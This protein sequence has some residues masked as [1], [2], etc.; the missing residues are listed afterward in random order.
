M[1]TTPAATGATAP[2]TPARLRRLRTG[3]SRVLLWAT[4]AL[5]VITTAL[6]LYQVFT[7][8]VLSSPVAFTEELVRYA[9]IWVSFIAGTY[10]F[11][12]REHMALTI[13]RDRL[14]ARG[15]RVLVT[16][17]DLLILALAVIILGAGGVL[18]AWSSRGDVSALLGI[19]R[20]LVYVIVPIA[21][22]GIALA[23]VLNI[24]DTVRGAAPDADPSTSME[25]E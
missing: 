10:A 1:S 21:G 16:G 25:S 20:G 14:P 2:G 24:I 19:S 7:R 6:V 11:L 4:V 23:Q 3:L 13:V 9:L 8:Y 22:A 15:R 17:I 5:L 18:L 12:E